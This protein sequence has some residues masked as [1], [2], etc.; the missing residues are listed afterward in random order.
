MAAEVAREPRPSALVVKSLCDFGDE[1]K[2]DKFQNY[3]AYTSSRF[4][5]EFALSELEPIASRRRGRK[6]ARVGRKTS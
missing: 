3:A 2:A 1:D 5:Y 4:L 6:A